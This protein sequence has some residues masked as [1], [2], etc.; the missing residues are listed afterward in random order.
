MLLVFQAV[1]LVLRILILEISIAITDFI[2]IDRSISFS[3]KTREILFFFLF[4]TYY[5][6]YIYFF[7]KNHNLIIKRENN[8]LYF[9]IN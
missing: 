5:S 2:G 3:K 8:K 4:L 7:E 9:Q 1:L 6:V